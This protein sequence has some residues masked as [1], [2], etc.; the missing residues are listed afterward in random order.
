MN[1]KPRLR[2]SSILH[3][4]VSADFLLQLG[5]D[6]FDHRQ[7]FREVRCNSRQTVETLFQ[8]LLLARQA[9]AWCC[10]GY[11]PQAAVGFLKK[12]LVFCLAQVASESL[13]RTQ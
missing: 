11:C 10:Q 3:G 5:D 9:L 7:P 1:S 8:R 2:S 13:Q 6:P 4:G 12:G